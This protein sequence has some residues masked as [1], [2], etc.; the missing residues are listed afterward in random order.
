MTPRLLIIGCGDVG[1]RVLRALAG[2]WRVF[3]LTSTPARAAA[4]RAAGAVPLV[5]NLDDAATLA[6]LAG[7]ADLVLHLAPPAR[8]GATDARTRRLLAALARRPPQAL[9]YARTTGVSGDC[10]GDFIDE[11]ATAGDELRP[12]PRRWD[13]SIG[14]RSCAIRT[15]K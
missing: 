11:R 2:R 6:R 15:S 3:A 13:R 14:C 4:L 10:Q 9:V 1:L 5:G 7:L 12:A 8:D